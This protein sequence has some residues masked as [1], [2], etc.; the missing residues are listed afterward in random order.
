[1]ETK[2]FWWQR[3]EITKEPREWTSRRLQAAHRAVQR[4]KDANALFPELCRFS[5][6]GERTEQIDSRQ[7]K[8]VR[9]MRSFRAQQWLGVRRQLRQ[10]PQEFR[11]RVLAKWNTGFMPGDPAHLAALI[12]MMQRA[13]A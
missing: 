12:L 3:Y 2:H 8:F 1:M 7:D 4:E 9:R 6:V 5:T 11:E 10:L 13:Q